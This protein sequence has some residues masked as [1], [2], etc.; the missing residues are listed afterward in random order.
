MLLNPASATSSAE[1]VAI[2]VRDLE[3]VDSPP[4]TAGVQSLKR[5]NGEVEQPLTHIIG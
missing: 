4:V 5:K 3:E 2:A 1:N